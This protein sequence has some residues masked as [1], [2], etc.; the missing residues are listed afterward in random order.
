MQAG[1][2]LEH[3]LARSSGDPAFILS[4]LAVA[5]FLGAAHALTP[6]H[7]KTIVAAYLVG[8]RGR[9]IDAFY[10]GGVVTL[11]HTFSVFVLGFIT[12]YASRQFAPDKIFPWLSLA[13]GLLVT[14][15]GGWLVFRRWGGGHE[16]SHDGHPHH[17]H[18]G[19]G[20]DHN[21]H[22]HNHAHGTSGLLSLGISGGLVP[23]PEAL[24][25]L[26]LSVSMGR[27][28]M[29][30]GL[31]TAFSLGLAAVLIVIGCA[32][33]L[34]G[35]VVKKV[36]GDSVWVKRLPIVSACVVTVLGLAMVVQAA[37]T[38]G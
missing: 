6:G 24:V 17:H 28:A 32:M 3:Y 2:G 16:H 38:L 26:M 34:A 12:L 36:G 5:F 21:H 29:G 20:H 37:R 25:V 33:V 14:G 22:H 11:T 10:L 35:P 1:S 9:L 15:I 31:L 7:G 18:H 30:L 4:A 23:C 19:H 27:I 13:S 8:S